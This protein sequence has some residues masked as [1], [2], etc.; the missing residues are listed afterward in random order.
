MPT[1]ISD[2]YRQPATIITENALLKAAYTMGTFKLVDYR[3]VY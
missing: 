1:I 3:W 2:N